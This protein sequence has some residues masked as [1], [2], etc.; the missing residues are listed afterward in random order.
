MPGIRRREFVSLIGGAAAAWP[1]AARSQQPDRM[2]RIGVLMGGP[3]PHDPDAQANIVAFLQVAAIGLDRWPQCAHRVSL[4][5]GETPL[6]KYAAELAELAPDVI[7][8]RGTASLAPL[9]QVDAYRTDRVCE[10]R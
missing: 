3:P 5:M 4:G 8:S 6:A 1:L 2:R 9:L 7:L 10:R